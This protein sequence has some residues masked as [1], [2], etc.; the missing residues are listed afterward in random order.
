MKL[1]ADHLETV[2]AA[3]AAAAARAGRRAEE[4]EL[5]AVSKTHPPE[6]VSE[7]VAAGQFVFGESRIQEARAKIPLS[8]GRARWHFIGHLQRNKIRHA[9]A[10]GFELLSEGQS[11]P[12]GGKSN[13][14]MRRSSG[15]MARP[16][17][18][19]HERKRKPDKKKPGKVKR[20]K[21]KTSPWKR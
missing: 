10:L 12:R 17:R 5:V 3:I 18:S 4:I 14:P 16:G 15:A 7:A 19:P 6:D 9:L 11:I 13:R 2:R 20:G 8:P 21:G 1:I